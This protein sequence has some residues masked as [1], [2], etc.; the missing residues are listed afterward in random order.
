[1]KATKLAR[2]HRDA[3][4]NGIPVPREL[5]LKIIKTDRF[6]RRKLVDNLTEFRVQSGGGHRIAMRV[7]FSKKGW[8]LYVFPGMLLFRAIFALFVGMFIELI[9]EDKPITEPL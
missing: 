4:E 2:F 9:F 1:M 7:P 3:I 8:S 6:D 5:L